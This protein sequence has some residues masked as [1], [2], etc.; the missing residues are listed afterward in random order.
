MQRERTSA[1]AFGLLLVAALVLGGSLGSAFFGGMALGKSQGQKEVR[2]ALPARSTSGLGQQFQGQLNQE[3][4]QQFRQ[5]SQGQS[6]LGDP[7]GFA[8]RGGLSGTLEKVEG[9]TLTINT[10]QGTLRATISTDTAIQV[11]AEGTLQDLTPGLQIT[12]V[13]QREGDGTVAARSII[14][15]GEGASFLGG[16]RESGQPS[17]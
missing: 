3:Q 4:L 2:T 1:R 5:Q 15:G 12:V 6:R 10:A 13:G 8:G 9:N 16:R 11:F 14:I 17:P 7:L